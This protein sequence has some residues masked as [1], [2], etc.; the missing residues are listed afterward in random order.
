M[1]ARVDRSRRQRTIARQPTCRDRPRQTVDTPTGAGIARACRL[2]NENSTRSATCLAGWLAAADLAQRS[3]RRRLA[4]WRRRAAADGWLAADGWPQRLAARGSRLA[5]RGSRLAAR[6]E[7]LARWEICRNKRG[8]AGRAGRPARRQASGAADRRGGRPASRRSAVPAAAGWP[9][10][11]I[12]LEG[13]H[14]GRFGAPSARVAPQRGCEQA[15]GPPPGA[16]PDGRHARSRPARI[17]RI[18]ARPAGP[19]NPRASRAS[20]WLVPR[21]STVRRV[22]AGMGWSGWESQPAGIRLAGEGSRQSGV[23]VDAFQ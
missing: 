12:S 7:W 11:P 9:A 17:S 2:P 6:G 20:P 19:A 10:F 22:S 8:R 18:P 1:A 15:S 16:S 13:R 4:G 21:V 14:A 5:A 3:T 23:A